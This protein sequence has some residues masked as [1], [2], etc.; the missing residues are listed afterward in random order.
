MH[1]ENDW[2]DQHAN[3]QTQKR[4][5]RA[6][7]RGVPERTWVASATILRVRPP[8][9]APKLAKIDGKSHQLAKVPG[10][11]HVGARGGANERVGRSN[12]K[13]QQPPLRLAMRIVEHNSVPELQKRNRE[14]SNGHT[15]NN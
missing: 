13:L 14:V 8:K 3:H 10:R 5:P 12:L 4:S 15:F 11:T 7:A 6:T 2:D 1:D 9:I